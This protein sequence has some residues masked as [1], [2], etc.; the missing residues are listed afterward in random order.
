MNSSQSLPSWFARGWSSQHVAAATVISFTWF[1]VAPVLFSLYL[2]IAEDE[3]IFF[4]AL[5]FSSIIAAIVSFL[6]S[7]FIY[8]ICQ[9]LVGTFLPYLR[10]GGEVFMALV[11][12]QQLFIW[13]GPFIM[14]I[15]DPTI[16]Q[17]TQHDFLWF[18]LLLSV[19]S[20]IHLYRYSLRMH[21]EYH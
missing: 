18:W 3:D 19:H 12:P 1:W 16:L 5:F 8:P 21:K 10:T 2:L 14:A 6:V 9:L 20:M 7:L 17:T 13:G 11:L 4:L 15:V